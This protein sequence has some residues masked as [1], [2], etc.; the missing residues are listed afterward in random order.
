MAQRRGWIVTTSEER[1]IH[2]VEKDLEAAGFS[3]GRVLEELGS[4][5]GSAEEAA[6]PALRRIRGVIDVSPD[7]E[8]SI[9]PPDADETW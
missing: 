4:I 7:R 2:D 9:G 3:V 6:V 5:T 8:V 1:P